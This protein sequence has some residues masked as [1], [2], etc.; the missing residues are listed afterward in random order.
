MNK[1]V[2]IFSIEKK[3]ILKNFPRISGVN[4]GLRSRFLKF[5]DSPGCQVVKVTALLQP[6][7]SLGAPPFCPVLIGHALFG[8]PLWIG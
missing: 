6:P 1:F 4:S 3:Y 2:E 5:P 8:I 7:G